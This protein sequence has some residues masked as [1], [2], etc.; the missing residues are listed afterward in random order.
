[1]VYAAGV[2]GI[3]IRSA[4]GGLTWTT[5]S[6]AGT[7]YRGSSAKGTKAWIVGDD[8]V[9][10]ASINNGVNF[11]PQTSNTTSDFKN[12]F[13]FDELTGYA[14]GQNNTLLYTGN[15]GTTWTS[16]NTGI[17]QGV[18]AIHFSTANTGWVTC[19]AGAVYMTTNAGVTWINDNSGV[20]VEMYD[21]F[22]SDINQGWIVGTGGT[23]RHRAGTIGIQNISSVAPENFNLSQ[24]YPNPF[25]PAT[26]I[27]FG[28]SKQS[29]VNLTV[30]DAAGRIVEELVNGNLS[31][32]IYEFD[33][34]ASRYS[35][36]VYFYTIKTGEFS[37]T[38]KMLL[39]K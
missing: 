35:S 11:T 39:V 21:V 2:D 1:M 5:V 23:I 16:R 15:G 22:F 36:G 33:W 34:N 7:R 31:A 20:V 29:L 25:N 30:Y 27:K 13:M 32:G 8:G 17:L 28:I 4:D 24:N 26:K 3:I 14:G 38:K 6:N 37:Q 10:T 12:I 9:I 18:N 19:G